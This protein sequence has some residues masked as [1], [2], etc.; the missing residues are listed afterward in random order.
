VVQNFFLSIK[1]LVAQITPPWRRGLGG[2]VAFVL[3]PLTPFLKGGMLRGSEFLSFNKNLS[4]TNYS[5]L[6]KGGGG[7]WHLIYYHNNLS[8]EEKSK[9]LISSLIVNTQLYTESVKFNTFY[10]RKVIIDGKGKIK[11]AILDSR[12][13]GSVYTEDLTKIVR[14][15]GFQKF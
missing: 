2:L 10:N 5:P 13:F 8:F 12:D 3:I 9:F 14:S 15:R 4:S 1:T 6:A 7:D 11:S